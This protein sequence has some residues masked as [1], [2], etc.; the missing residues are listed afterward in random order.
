V[1]DSLDKLPTQQPFVK[2]HPLPNTNHTDISK[3]QIDPREVHHVVIPYSQLASATNRFYD[4]PPEPEFSHVKYSPPVSKVIKTSGGTSADILKPKTS[5]N[6]SQ[7]VTASAMAR[8]STPQE[9]KPALQRSRSS[10][11]E[12]RSERQ[13]IRPRSRTADMWDIDDSKLKSD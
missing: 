8:R 11:L 13:L 3:D 5:G 6:I 12:I 10:D 4:W 9:F 1:P 7:F 2:A